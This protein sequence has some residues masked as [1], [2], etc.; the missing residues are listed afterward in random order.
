VPAAKSSASNDAAAVAPDGI[1]IHVFG[2]PPARLVGIAEGRIAPGTYSIHRH[3]TLEQYTYVVSGPVIALTS[4]GD[5]GP[6]KRVE[7]QSGDLLLTLPWESLQFVN[8]SSSIARVLFICAP[9]YPPD[10]ADTRLL[11]DHGL[12]TE[13]EV[14]DAVTRLE[15]LRKSLNDEIDARLKQLLVQVGKSDGAGQL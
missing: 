4:D 2:V 8:E 13:A 15:D 1:A 6:A 14:R 12:P 5:G 10:D 9:P 7:L 3:L 11:D